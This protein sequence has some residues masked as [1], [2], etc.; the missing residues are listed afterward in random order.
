M[1]KYIE[2]IDLSGT[3]LFISDAE[4]KEET[5][6]L[7]KRFGQLD[8]SGKT[9][10]IGDSYGEGYT[11]IFDNTGAIKGYTIKPW[12][13]YVIENCGITDY[14][15][16]CR[17]GSGFAVSNNT[18]ESL[19]DS[20]QVETPD[21]VKNIVVCG[22]YNEPSDINAIQTAEMS[23]YSKAKSKFPNSKIFCGMIGWDVNSSNWE[24]LN[25]V[26]IAYQYNAVDW[27]YLNNV[28]Y[29]IHSDGLMG[30]DGFHPNETGYSK[31]GLYVSEALKTGSCNPSFFNVNATV[32]FSPKWTLAP[33]SVWPI[34]TNYE[35][36][37]SRIIWGN[38]VIAPVGD[39][40][41]KCDGTEYLIVAIDST[42]YIG[43][44]AGYSVIDSSVIVQSGALFYTIPCQYHIMG[45]NI[46]M[47]FYDVDDTHTNYRTLTDVKQVQIKRESLVE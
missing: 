47:S 24:K 36:N 34:V 25:K 44:G 22:G 31:I 37:K 45:R 9:V 8:L 18:F 17:G 12:E 5:K 7:W 32:R 46:Y 26:C 1:K 6:R 38:T 2:K 11:T 33:G 28:Q 39:T 27:F 42:S 16:S 3:E 13:N 30:A 14:V 35:V 20:I 21:S 29:S 40:T 43:D 41:I 10:F 4:S 19:L 23:F 15:I